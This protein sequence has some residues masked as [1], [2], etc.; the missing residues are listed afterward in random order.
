M[1]IFG[2]R[3]IQTTHRMFLTLLEEGRNLPPEVWANDPSY[4]QRWSNLPV[5]TIFR[6]TGDAKDIR[7]IG[8]CIVLSTTEDPLQSFTM[9]AGLVNNGRFKVNPTVDR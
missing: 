8:R 6:V 3:P 2:H 9:P 5:G 7:G 4:A 1:T